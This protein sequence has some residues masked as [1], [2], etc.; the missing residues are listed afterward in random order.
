[1]S[2][3]KL[4]AI[5]RQTGSRLAAINKSIYAEGDLIGEGYRIQAIESDRVWF[6]GP[7]GRESLGFEKPQPP[8]AKTN[9]P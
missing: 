5:W 7:T 1:M 4:K 3:W 8:V 2:H 6:Q 9:A